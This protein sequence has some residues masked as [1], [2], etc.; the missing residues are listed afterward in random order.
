MVHIITAVG[1]LMCGAGLAGL[2]FPAFIT[3]TASRVA[4]SRPLRITAIATRILFGAIAILYAEQTLYP[5]P[6]K[7][8]GVIAIMGGTVTAMIGGEALGGFLGKIRDDSTWVRAISLAAL[9]AGAFLV[10]A[11]VQPG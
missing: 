2:V 8:I 7:I 1:V 11:S 10:H 5:W 3:E 9:A 6:M 4:T